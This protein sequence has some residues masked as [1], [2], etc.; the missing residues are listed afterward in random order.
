MRGELAFVAELWDHGM[1]VLIHSAVM[2]STFYTT[3][4]LLSRILTCRLAL[5]LEIIGETER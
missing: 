1:H 3:E 4:V 5:Y 2:L